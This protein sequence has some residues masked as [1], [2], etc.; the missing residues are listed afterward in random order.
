MHKQPLEKFSKK[1]VLKNFSF[2]Y[3]FQFRILF[4][5]VSLRILRI[6]SK[7]GKMRTRITP[8]TDTFYE[9]FRPLL[10]RDISRIVFKFHYF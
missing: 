9:V 8:N 2:Q 6:Q 4:Y 10:Y 7:Y 5:S 1:A 3:S